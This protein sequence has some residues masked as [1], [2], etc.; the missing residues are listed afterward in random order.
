MKIFTARNLLTVGGIAA[1]VSI[2][3]VGTLF[4]YIRTATSEV[5]KSVR[6]AVPI[7]FE[8]KRLEQLT[9]EMIPEIQGNQKVA[10]QLDV[11]IE[12]LEREVDQL[13]NDSE[14]GHQQMR[15]LRNALADDNSVPYRFG[16]REY[17]HEEIEQDLERRLTA[18]NDLQLRIT[19]KR[20]LLKTRRRTLDSAVAKIHA[21]RQQHTL[22][23]E[24]TESLHA[25]LK[26]LELAQA[27]GD[28][29]FDETRLAR[30]RDLTSQLEKRIRTLQRLVEGDTLIASGIPVEIDGRSI[31]ERYDDIMQQR[32]DIA[33]TLQQ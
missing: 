2:I 5:T 33:A 9:S 4:S 12:F 23:T 21:C 16:D 6:D 15:K 20:R 24:K 11:E 14:T 22:L 29:S 26:L 31:V 30:A 3:G 18:W 17:S 32:D 13:E 1:V 25:E 28:V 7:E 8:L 19:A 27:T 10:A